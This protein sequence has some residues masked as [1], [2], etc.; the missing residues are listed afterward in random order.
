MPLSLLLRITA[1]AV[2][3][4]AQ[5][6]ADGPK[7][8]DDLVV[9]RNVE[10]ARRGETSLT[11]HIFHGK[12]APSGPKPC[13]VWIHGGGWKSGIKESGFSMLPVFAKNGYVC[14]TIGYRFSQDAIFPAQINDCKAAIRYLR[15][16]AEKYEIDP[17]RIGVWGI[18]AGGH[19]CALLGT[20]GDVKEL[21]GDAPWSDQSSRVQAVCDFCGPSDFVSW[22]DGKEMNPT[23]GEAIGQL[24]GGEYPATA[25]LAKEA[26]P[27]TYASADDPPFLIMHGDKDGLVPLKQAELLE[28]ALKKAGVDATLDVIEG[29]GHV[30]K[31][32]LD[33]SGK[34]V[35]AFFE[36]HLKK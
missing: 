33:D 10:Y 24:L 5:Q 25:K 4:A 6:P 21:D 14:A 22:Y 36:K 29:G 16:H 1:V 12:D 31:L 32:D 19:L 35:F 26:S 18:S 2:R 11:M 34:K 7:P 9:E 13:I 20:S 28:A 8:A 15:A 27:V 17:K 3:L 30:W 23:A